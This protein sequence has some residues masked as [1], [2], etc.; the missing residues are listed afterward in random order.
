[1]AYIKLTAA[2]LKD[3]IPVLT[4][5][6]T[7]YEGYYDAAKAYSKLSIVIYNNNL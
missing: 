3:I 2:V 4:T 6:L 1:M 5:E 7:S